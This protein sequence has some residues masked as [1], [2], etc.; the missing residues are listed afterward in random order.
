[1]AGRSG[2]RDWL[3]SNV[4]TE[5]NPT[6][7]D[8][9][10]ERLWPSLTPQQFLRDLLASRE[11]LVA[12]AGDDF[13]A[14]DVNRLLRTPANRLT[15]ETWSDADIALLDEA[16][17]L[18]NGQGTT[19]RHVVIDEAQDLSPMQ[20]RSA[21]RRSRNGSMT[22][23]GD[24]AQST[25]PWAREAWA[26]VVDA[27]RQD[28][29]AEVEE[30]TLGYRVPE[31]IYSLA[32]RLLPEAA[33]SVTV[34]RIVRVGPSDPDLIQCAEDQRIERAL[35]SA[36]E[37]AGRGLFVG[38]IVADSMRADLVTALT[39]AGIAWS[40]ASKGDLS[41][42][43]NVLSAEQAKG[44]EFDAVVLIEPEAIVEESESGLR[45]LYIALTRSTRYLT[46]V[47]SGLLIPSK[48]PRPTDP[49]EKGDAPTNNNRGSDPQVEQDLFDEPVEAPHAVIQPAII[50]GRGAPP[51]DPLFDIAVV[52]SSSARPTEDLAKPSA[53]R[54]V[55]PPSQSGAAPDVGRLVAETVAASLAQNIRQNV[56]SAQWAYLVDRIRRE[57]D[58][59]SD[60]I[61][62]LLT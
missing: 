15:E 7:I 22:V 56:S 28:L 8:A 25:G 45:L 42:S 46:V 29:P 34:P 40:D 43:I 21:R 27:L 50:R 54:P 4:T 19:Y 36:K 13:T 51:P 26:E 6:Q 48:Q 37:Y 31:Q 57:L 30:L 18:I 61:L 17:I 53:G 60:E 14:G 52:P 41:K 20:L 16:S 62:D 44:L 47:Y 32:A 39:E 9:A 10:L 58:V 3:T 59:S 12:A 1:M 33:P 5:A 11:R 24:I 49:N 2:F 38:L 35:A 55:A 23:V